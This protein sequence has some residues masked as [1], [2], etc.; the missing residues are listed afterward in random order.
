MRMTRT[1]AL[2]RLIVALA[3]LCTALVFA[4]GPAQ[5]RHPDLELDDLDDDTLDAML[6]A[7]LDDDDLIACGIGNPHAAVSVERMFAV[8]MCALGDAGDSGDERALDL[9]DLEAEMRE[10]G[11]TLRDVVWAAIQE[12]DELASGPPALD[13]RRIAVAY[14]AGSAAAGSRAGEQLL[15]FKDKRIDPGDA[16]IVPVKQGIVERVRAVRQ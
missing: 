4:T 3:L 16:A 9:D 11:T 12:A 14:P 13:V 6:Q 1:P 8:V 7:E 15:V 5:A 2:R 10:A